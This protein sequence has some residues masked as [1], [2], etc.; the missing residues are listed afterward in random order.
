MGRRTVHMD[1]L[2][3][4]SIIKTRLRQGEQ[5]IWHGAPDPIQ[6]AAQGPLRHLAFAV[7]FILLP[8][9]FLDL[10]SSLHLF[11]ALLSCSIGT[12]MAAVAVRS[13]AQ[14]WRTAYAVTNERVIIA[15]GEFGETKSFGSWALSSVHRTESGKKGSLLFDYSPRLA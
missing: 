5:V 11:F 15:V 3:A 2:Q 4:L 13:L 14:C 12:G 10:H 8:L 1:D 9:I 6:A 7:L